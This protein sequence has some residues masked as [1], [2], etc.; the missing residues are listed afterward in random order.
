M[1]IRFA[2]F[3]NC[4]VYAFEPVLLYGILEDGSDVFKA[5]EIAILL[6]F[7]HFDKNFP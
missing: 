2:L 5:K 4:I 3:I 7:G 1:N 6:I